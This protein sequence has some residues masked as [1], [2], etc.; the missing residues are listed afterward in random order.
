MKTHRIVFV[1]MLMLAGASRG[2]NPGTGL[3]GGALWRHA[4][5]RRRADSDGG[6]NLRHGCQHRARDPRRSPR[7]RLDRVPGVAVG[8]RRIRAVQSGAHHR[9]PATHAQPS[10]VQRQPVHQLLLPRRSAQRE[11][12]DEPDRARRSATEKS[13]RRSRLRFRAAHADCLRRDPGCRVSA[14]RR[15]P[16]HRPGCRI[17]RFDAISREIVLRAFAAV[18]GLPYPGARAART[19]PRRTILGEFFGPE[20]AHSGRAQ[21]RQ[22]RAVGSRRST[23]RPARATRCSRPDS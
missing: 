18:V 1:L 23:V 8:E 22:R 21:R 2:A 11:G 17:E 12:A 9:F 20:C 13:R 14:P 6:V 15:Q 7:A 4:A 10:G 19:S 16:R 3:L 5:V